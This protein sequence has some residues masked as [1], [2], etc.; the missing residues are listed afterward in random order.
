MAFLN[1]GTALHNLSSQKTSGVTLG[2]WPCAFQE[3]CSSSLCTHPN[4]HTDNTSSNHRLQ[5][6]TT[7]KHMV[8]ITQKYTIIKPIKK[9]RSN[10]PKNRKLEIKPC[11]QVILKP[12]KN[13]WIITFNGTL[14]RRASALAPLPAS[15]GS[16]FL[17]MAFFLPSVGL[18]QKWQSK[19]KWAK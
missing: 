1:F 3:P 16:S 17:R 12:N 5:K 11:H 13:I 19:K 2:Q 9:S 7:S 18:G 15:C 6:T 14:K 10:K 8:Y 4:K